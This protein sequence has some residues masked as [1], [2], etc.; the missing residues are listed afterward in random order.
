MAMAS[1]RSALGLLTRAIA[2][3]SPAPLHKHPHTHDL[4][5]NTPTHAHSHLHHNR[6]RIHPLAPRWAKRAPTVLHYTCTQWR[7]L[8]AVAKCDLRSPHTSRCAL[9]SQASPPH[10]IQ[11]CAFTPLPQ[12]LTQTSPPRQHAPTTPHHARAQGRQPHTVFKCHH[13]APH[14]CGRP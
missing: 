8:H 14:S 13:R 6:T 3:Q 9:T 11:I 5:A 12:P 2:P 4:H 1:P 10:Q 7:T